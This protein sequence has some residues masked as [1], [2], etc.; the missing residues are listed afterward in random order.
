M[1]TLIPTPYSEENQLARQK[2]RYPDN[3]RR[4]AK[5]AGREDRPRA[6]KRPH[7]DVEAEPTISV[8]SNQA[9]GS[10]STDTKLA[11]PCKPTPCSPQAP[12]SP[13]SQSPPPLRR[14]APKEIKKE[15]MAL[16]QYLSPYPA[17]PTPLLFPYTPLPVASFDFYQMDF[18]RQPTWSAPPPLLQSSTHLLQ[19]PPRFPLPLPVV[20]TEAP[21][22]Q[23]TP[24]PY[25]PTP[26][27]NPVSPLLT[28][29]P[30]SYFSPVPTPFAQLSLPFIPDSKP[31]VYLSPEEVARE[32]EERRAMEG[33]ILGVGVDEEQEVPSMFAERIKLEEL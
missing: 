32:E 23:P 31:E 12:P 28:S 11:S 19:S 16:P 1:L 26:R 20:P 13:R 27:S 29:P 7:L 24:W 30:T 4:Q 21:Q 18:Q 17:G 15:S 6:P 2:K 25:L 33:W 3:S 8:I 14:A 5:R 10:S 22:C 9:L